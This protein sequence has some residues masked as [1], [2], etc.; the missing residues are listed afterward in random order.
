MS[1]SAK[2]T[3]KVFKSLLAVTLSVSLCPLA[4]AGQAQADEAEN[5]G[6]EVSVS[7]SSANDGSETNSSSAS[8]NDG[9]EAS[10]PYASANDSDALPGDSDD[11]IAPERDALPGDF[12][13]DIDPQSV[14]SSDPIVDWTTCGTARWTIDAGG[15]L[16]I[17]PMEGTDNGELEIWVLCDEVPWYNYRNSI[18]SAKVAGKIATQTT[19]LMFNDCPKLASLDLSGLDTSDVTNMSNMFSYCWSLT[20]LDLS[21]LD[22][23]NVTNMRGMFSECSSLASLDLSPLDTSNVTDMSYMLS[24][25][26]KLTSLDLSPLDTSKVTNMSYMLYYCPS[27]TSLDLSPLDTSNVTSMRGIFAHCSKLAS[28]DLS[29]L[30]TSNVTNMSSMLRGCSRISSFDLSPLDTSNVTDMSYMLSGCS[31]L[32]SLD[33]SS[34]DTSQVESMGGMFDGCSRLASLD[35]SSFDTSNVTGMGGIFAHCSKLASLDL[36]S[37]DTSNVTGM[38]RMFYGCSSLASLDVSSFDTSGAVGMKGMFSGCSKLALLD[39][40]SFDT[41]RVT[42]MSDMFHGCSSLTSLDVSSFDTSR[43][44]D[45]SDMFHGCSSLSSLDVSSFDTSNAWGMKG[46]F[47]GC[48]EL[49]SLDL[50]SFNTWLVS[51]LS[52]MFSGCS[53]LK[54]LDLSSFDTSY[55]LRMNDMF[56]GCSSLTSLDLSSFDTSRTGE[57]VSIFSGC[58]SLRTVKLGAGFTFTGRWTGRICNLPA[59]SDLNGYTG[60]WVSSAD[61]EAYKP[62]A[63]P[64]NVAAVYTA[65]QKPGV[66]MGDISSAI[67]SDIPEQTCTGLRIEPEVEV[68]LDGKTLVR[69]VDFRV[70]CTNNIKVGTAT[71]TIIGIGDYEGVIRKHFSIKKAP[72]PIFADVDYSSW[73]GDAV[74]FVAEKDLV[75]GYSDSGLFGVGNAL[76]RAQLATILYRNANPD[77]SPDFRPRNT[78]GMPDVEGFTWYTAGVN[79]AVENGVIN[80]YADG[81]GNRVAFGPDDSMTLEQLVTAIANLSA[82]EEDLPGTGE[83]AAILR[84]FRDRWSVSPWARPSMAWAAQKGLV[85]GYDEPDGKHLRPSE[86]I[87]RERAVVILMRAF[88]L[89]ILE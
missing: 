47:N 12:D 50:S 36:S 67:V 24:G 30:D 54:S 1:I 13:D 71:A 81:E 15:C 89:G 65:Q 40:S 14:D 77:A 72:T 80:G 87:S 31:K 42:D 18:T 41:S 57:M 29:P 26:S 52:D 55:V 66:V 60:L 83:T 64:N 56:N 78:T 51:N 33:L 3:E 48:S 88:E 61:G 76:T 75:T 32:T 35:L 25:C 5:D 69:G 79:W 19:A 27:L 20:S 22:T 74:T 59:I 85:A 68:T 62:N 70:S 17:A 23:S 4:P 6:S 43:V 58:L 7:S 39:V 73:Y 10:I 82:D 11:G 21:P 9:S 84:P 28:L 38:S 2:P 46:M 37:F 53:S 34:F 86:N 49:V 63:I 8:V 45:M 16:T 44:T